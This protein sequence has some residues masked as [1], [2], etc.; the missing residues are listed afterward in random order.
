MNGFVRERLG[1]EEKIEIFGWGIFGERVEERDKK[2]CSKSDLE[3]EREREREITKNGV[4]NTNDILV[5]S[6]I[7]LT[8]VNS[9]WSHGSLVLV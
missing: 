4:R 6:L 7:E 3:R 5:F 8:E 9:I 1:F 2:K